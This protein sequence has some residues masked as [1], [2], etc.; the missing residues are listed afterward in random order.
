MSVLLLYIFL[1]QNVGVHNSHTKN[2]TLPHWDLQWISSIITDALLCRC[3]GGRDCLAESGAFSSIVFNSYFFTLMLLPRKL[4]W[5]L[6]I[7]PLKRK[8][9]WGSMF[10]CSF[11]RLA[12]LY[13]FFQN[14]IF[15][16]AALWLSVAVNHNSFEALTLLNNSILIYLLPFF[17]WKSH[18]FGATYTKTYK[19]VYKSVSL[20]PWLYVAYFVIFFVID[21]HVFSFQFLMWFAYVPSCFLSPVLIFFQFWPI[22]DQLRQFCCSHSG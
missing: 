14:A 15:M 7:T 5:N 21:V 11:N 10:F 16:V 22:V 2:Y 3:W 18:T 17:F 9:I 6:K 1:P 4:T 13:L 20:L 12:K 8:L 19:D